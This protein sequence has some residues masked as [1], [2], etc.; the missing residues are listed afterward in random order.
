MR[1]GILPTPDRCDV[2]L[3]RQLDPAQSW[4]WLAMLLIPLLVLL[5]LS[6]CSK[7]ETPQ[8]AHAE[9][10]AESE[11]SSTP[12]ENVIVDAAE[13]MTK[14]KAYFDEGNYKAAF[15]LLDQLHK[16]K[17]CPPEGYAIRAQI[18][19]HSGLSSQAISSMSL[20]ITRKPDV[21][22]WHNMLGMLFVKTQN[23]TMALQSFSKAIELDAN[24]AKAYNNRGL[25]YVS[26]RQFEQAVADFDAATARE[27]NYVD[28]Y[29]NRGYAFLEQGDFQKAIENFSR[30]VEI[31]PNYIKGYN[32][33]GF[34]LMK[35]GEAERAIAD[36]TFAIEK[37]PYEVK[38]Y[39]HRRDAYQAL[40]KL[41]LANQD[42]QNAQWVQNILVLTRKLQRD[43]KNPSL[44]VERAELFVK[45]KKYEDAKRDLAEAIKL[46]NTFAPALV[47][48]ATVA[49]AQDNP[50]QAIELCTKALE[51][52]ENFDANSI[53][54]DAYMA[55]GKLDQAIN[56]YQAAQRFD[57]TVA[58]AYWKRAEANQSDPA[59][60][61]QDRKTALQLDPDIEKHVVK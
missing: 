33:R 44:F 23:L 52:G 28:A 11:T 43:Q 51:F 30:C 36:F 15:P 18:L 6:G 1:N 19:D 9:Q 31:D 32:N 20:A 14:V 3:T 58:M 2:S 38:H 12:Q 45:N 47:V 56:D 55:L 5:G 49:M 39:L 24:H 10:K 13:A 41:D 22:E 54:G 27:K 46:D 57:N 60:A 26:Q 48:E 37:A 59:A 25:I 50:D 61:E 34:A 8:N 7:T 17:Q 21:A 4:G 29:N 53:R 42:Q 16:A 35:V 40:G